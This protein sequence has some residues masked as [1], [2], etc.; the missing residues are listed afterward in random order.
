MNPFPPQVGHPIVRGPPIGPLCVTMA[1]VP[2]QIGHF[3]LTCTPLNRGGLVVVT[4]VRALRAARRCSLCTLHSGHFQTTPVPLQFW[5]GRLKNRNFLS[6]PLSLHQEQIYTAN[7]LPHSLRVNAA[8]LPGI[9]NS[10]CGPL[11]RCNKAPAIEPIL[12][13]F[14]GGLHSRLIFIY[15]T[16]RPV[17]A[18]SPEI[19]PPG[20]G[21]S[22]A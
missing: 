16:Y 12:G 17:E 20:D 10:S 22:A 2:L 18:W 14:T 13:D 11:H 4:P 9:I 7:R 15:H 19:A 1:R 3:F 5:Q 21:R 8:S 6:V